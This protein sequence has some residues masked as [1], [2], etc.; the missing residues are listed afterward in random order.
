MHLSLLTLTTYGSLD[1]LYVL[2]LPKTALTD[3]SKTKRSAVAKTLISLTGAKGD[4][5]FSALLL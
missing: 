4:Q 1:N 2:S 3:Y 5:N